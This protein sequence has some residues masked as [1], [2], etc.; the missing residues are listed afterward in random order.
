MLIGIVAGVALAVA[1]ALLGALIDGSE[2]GSLDPPPD[3]PAPEASGA[4]SSITERVRRSG[5]GRTEALSLPGRAYSSTI[6]PLLPPRLRASRT[7]SMRI[8]RSTALHMS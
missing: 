3:T 6:S 8:P 1:A 4:A 2:S 5:P 7:P